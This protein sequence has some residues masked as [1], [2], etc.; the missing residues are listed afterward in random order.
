MR[1]FNFRVLVLFVPMF[2]LNDLNAQNSEKPAYL[3]TSLPAEQRAAD[4]VH[5]MTVEEKVSQLVNQ[6]RAI[7]RLNVPDYDWW[8]EALHGVANNGGITTFP[9]PVGLAATFD[10]DVIHRMAIATSVEGRIKYVQGTATATSLRVST[11]GRRTSTSFAIP[12]GDAARKPT[13]KTRS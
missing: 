10:T 12:V 4:L 2:A 11:S 7:P 5:H 9:E 13:G 8:S 3:N 1:P 6:S